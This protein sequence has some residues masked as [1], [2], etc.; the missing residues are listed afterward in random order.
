MNYYLNVLKSYANLSGRTGRREFW[1][2]TIVN[3]MIA[4]VAAYL[5]MTL[6][7]C[8][9]MDVG[10]GMVTTP[11]G[12]MF[13]LVTLPV[14]VPGLAVLVRRLHDVGKSGWLFFVGLVPVVGTIW[15]LVLL[16]MPGA[17]GINGYERE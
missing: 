15:L 1:I 13:V 4:A 5:D 12:Y 16:C 10:V 2:F 3:I 9:K 7:I 14:L 17:P 8:F 6:G 11:F